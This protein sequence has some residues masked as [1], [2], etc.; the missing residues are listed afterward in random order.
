MVVRVLCTA[1]YFRPVPERYASV[2][3]KHAIEYD[4]PAVAQNM[5]ESDL[6]AIIEQYDGVIAGDDEFTARVIEKGAKARLKVIAKWGVGINAIDATAAEKHGVAVRRSPRLL[7]DAVAD[8]AWGSILLLARQL[9][10]S[11]RRVRGGEWVKLPGLGLRGRT[12]GIIGVG[13]IGQQIALR[14]VPFGVHLLGNDIRTI[15]PAFLSGCGMEMVGKDELLRRSDFV[16][17]ACDLNPTSF[18]ILDRKDFALFKPSAFL[19]NIARGALV[20]T[21]ALVEALREH[22]LGGAGLDVFE[23]EPLPKDSPLRGFDNVVLNAHNAF[24][25]DTAVE[26]VN[27]NTVRQLLLVLKPEAARDLPSPS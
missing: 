8:A 27:E 25:A 12:L 5:S 1:P 14:G 6:L 3:R 9:H 21:A 10:I 16:V 17:L 15:D 11:D 18:H 2:F 4:S 23:D 26:A 13:D 24:N 20:V 22:R 7:S 19:V